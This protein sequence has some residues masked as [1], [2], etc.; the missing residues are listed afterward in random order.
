[1]HGF[2]PGA[3]SIPIYVSFGSLITCSAVHLM[4][5]LGEAMKWGLMSHDKR[6]HSLFSN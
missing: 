5:E 1:M 3:E 6:L 2:C 4:A